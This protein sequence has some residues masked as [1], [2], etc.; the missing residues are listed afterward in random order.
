MPTIIFDNPKEEAA[1][2]RVKY[3][4]ICTHQTLPTLS[5]CISLIVN[6]KQSR[7]VLYLIWLKLLFKQKDFNFFKITRIIK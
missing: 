6:V 7:F 3:A 2:I 1:D 5:F 4:L